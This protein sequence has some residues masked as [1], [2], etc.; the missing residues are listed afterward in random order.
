MRLS[1]DDVRCLW[2]ASGYGGADDVHCYGDPGPAEAHTSEW[3]YHSPPSA[4]GRQARAGQSDAGGVGSRVRVP[5][6]ATRLTASSSPEA[7]RAQ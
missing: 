5:S 6:P 2:G 1:D 3:H 4:G 7:R